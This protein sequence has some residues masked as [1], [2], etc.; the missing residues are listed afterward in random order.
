MCC[1]VLRDPLSYMAGTS[2]ITD[3][4]SVISSFCRSKRAACV[5]HHYS[6]AGCS[7]SSKP[8]GFVCF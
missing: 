4:D 6:S 2:M 5:N 8:F 3:L 1:N 7:V